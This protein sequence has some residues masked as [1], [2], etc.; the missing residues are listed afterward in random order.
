MKI[1][2][3]PHRTIAIYTRIYTYMRC[4]QKRE[5]IDIRRIANY[6]IL[7]YLSV[8]TF[9][10]TTTNTTYTQSVSTFFAYFSK[11]NRRQLA[12]HCYRD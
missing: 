10:S 6:S 1:H 11:V 8:K 3:V 2:R 12:H 5:L 4:I 9:T 7:V